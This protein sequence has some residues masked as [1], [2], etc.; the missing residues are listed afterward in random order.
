[1][2][3]L[4]SPLYGAVT[5]FDLLTGEE[6]LNV[7]VESGSN[8]S[9]NKFTRCIVTPDGEDY[10]V[11][12]LSDISQG[13]KNIQPVRTQGSFLFEKAQ[14]YRFDKAGKACWNKPVVLEKS[15]YCCEYPN[16]LPVLVFANYAVLK[17]NP[18]VMEAKIHLIDKKTG[19]AYTLPYL[20]ELSHFTLFGSPRE[21][22]FTIRIPRFPDTVLKFSPN[23]VEKSADKT[24]STLVELPPI[25]VPETGE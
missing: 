5:V 21:D 17:N 22:M 6:K 12:A 18:P 13:V 24:E 16:R 1:M 10:L 9:E 2:A 7:K 14:I 23:P 15:A 3:S 19:Q 20:H 11:A 25:P 8:N 4:I